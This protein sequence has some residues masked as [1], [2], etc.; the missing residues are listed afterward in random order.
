MEHTTLNRIHV[1]P[2][3]K[4]AAVQVLAHAPSS[5]LFSAG[6]D[7]TKLIT[8][9]ENVPNDTN[10]R[11]A[12]ITTVL[13]HLGGKSQKLCRSDFLLCEDCNSSEYCMYGVVDCLPK[14]GLPIAAST[15]LFLEGDPIGYGMNCI[16]LVQDQIE[17]RD[18]V[19]AQQSMSSSRIKD[20]FKNIMQAVTM[21]QTENEDADSWTA[22]KRDL[23]DNPDFGRQVVEKLTSECLIIYKGQYLT[24]L[25]DRLLVQEYFSSDNGPISSPMISLGVQEARIE[26]AINEIFSKVQIAPLIDTV[27]SV[28][29]L[30]LFEDCLK[31]YLLSHSLQQYAEGDL[32]EVDGIQFKFLATEPVSKQANDPADHLLMMPSSLIAGTTALLSESLNDIGDIHAPQRDVLLPRRIGPRTAIYLGNPIIP[33]WVDILPRHQQNAVRRLPPQLQTYALLRQIGES[34]PHDIDRILRTFDMMAN[35][36]TSVHFDAAQDAKI[37]EACKKF[38]VKNPSG[39]LD[40]FY[41]SVCLTDKMADTDIVL[42][43]CNHQF[44]HRCVV[45]WFRRTF[46][47]PL[48]KRNLETNVT[49]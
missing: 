41:C 8:V 23:C 7:D 38:M 3:T 40:S 16:A 20:F 47:C 6:I 19:A 11:K 37:T 28:Y 4:A 46:T 17:S 5:R 10:T 9:G 15:A 49:S 29:R 36:R 18:A 22:S 30:N 35:A 27:P 31:P 43:P 32:L 1:L 12:Q 44:H 45:H 21:S 33:H 24:I 34:S 42:L 39:A 13:R 14:P 2:L 25:R 48:C 26:I